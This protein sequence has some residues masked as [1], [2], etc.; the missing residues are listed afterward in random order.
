MMTDCVRWFSHGMGSFDLTDPSSVRLTGSVENPFEIIVFVAVDDDESGALICSI[1]RFL[2]ND[3]VRIGSCI[4]KYGTVV[5]DV[6]NDG[7]AN[8]WLYSVNIFEL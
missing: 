2:T 1:G 6:S 8:N 7:F 5:A 4:A 3:G